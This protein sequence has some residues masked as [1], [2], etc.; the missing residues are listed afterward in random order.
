MED[1][2]E[3]A[4]LNAGAIFSPW[5]AIILAA[6]IWACVGILIWDF[7]VGG[8]SK[9]ALLFAAGIPLLVVGVILTFFVKASIKFERWFRE[10]KR[11]LAAIKADNDRTDALLV[12]TDGDDSRS[13]QE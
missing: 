6:L 13:D 8:M 12:E 9:R 1:E 4:E 2:K 7:A 5:F 11:E 10:L 3:R